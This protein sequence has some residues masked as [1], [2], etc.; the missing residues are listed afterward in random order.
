[1]T[2]SLT[3]LIL[4]TQGRLPIAEPL[5]ASRFADVMP[6]AARGESVSE[7]VA[8]TSSAETASQP[9]PVEHVLTEPQIQRADPRVLASQLSP[10]EHLL[11]E[12]QM[13]RAGAPAPPNILS[14][15]RPA[16]SEAS[17]LMASALQPQMQSALPSNLH[18]EPS[19][20]RGLPSGRIA[21]RVAVDRHDA[22]HQE[23][24]I[25]RD[26][27]DADVTEQSAA[28]REHETA[29]SL[30]EHERLAGPLESQPGPP[31][32]NQTRPR[33]DVSQSERAAN[34]PVGIPQVNAAAPEVH[35]SIG[36]I[37]VHASAA[38]PLP[39]PSPRPTPHRRPT[40]SLADYL[41]QRG[42]AR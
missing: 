41:T 35:I 22:D 1:M 26:V 17:S 4:R 21:D 39:A 33:A 30:T 42:N 34:A 5:L 6:D 13:Q 25:T 27:R 20:V 24:R 8:P 7:V 11:T 36:R 3:R 10:V 14:S 18:G 23:R 9:S 28:R 12:A 19:P 2:D 15:S 37:E 16:V 40:V 38:P 29:P 32:A 31:Q